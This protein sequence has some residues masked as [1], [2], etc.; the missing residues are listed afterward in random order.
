MG[1]SVLYEDK[2][3]I[4]INKENGVTVIPGRGK[5]EGESLIQNVERITSQKLYVVHRIDKETSGVILFAKDSATHRLL[6]IQFEKKEIQKEYLAVVKDIP[7]CNGIIDSPIFEFGSGRMGVD[8]R[9]KSSLTKFRMLH[10]YTAS[11]MINVFPHTGRRHQIRVHLYSIGHP[12]L[13]DTMYGNPRPV[14]GCKRLMLHANQIR[15]MHPDG[16]ERT[17][18]AP[19]NDSWNEILSQIE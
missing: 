9:G 6:N 3:L 1:L 8:K 10:K 18:T 14:G 13:G 4:V 11:S 16:K 5:N 2:F 15:F 7:D 19:V 12:I 17:I